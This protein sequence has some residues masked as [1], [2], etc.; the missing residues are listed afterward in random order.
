ML[1]SINSALRVQNLKW[2]RLGI[3]FSKNTNVNSQ[4]SPCQEFWGAFRSWKMGQSLMG[5]GSQHVA[6]NLRHKRQSQS[7]THTALLFLTSLHLCFHQKWTHEFKQQQ[8]QTQDQREVQTRRKKVNKRDG[9]FQ[10]IARGDGPFKS[11]RFNKCLAQGHIVGPSQLH[12]PILRTV[13]GYGWLVL[14]KTVLHVSLVK[15]LMWRLS[16]YLIKLSLQG[17]NNTNTSSVPQPTVVRC[18]PRKQF[19][20]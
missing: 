19:T 15:I 2:K 9:C 4:K 20:I 1:T 14:L 5:E 12:W 7:E 10:K 13:G 3:N 18:P 17:H 11:F 8:K 16:R 6:G